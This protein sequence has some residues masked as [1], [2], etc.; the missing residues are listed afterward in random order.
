MKT[1]IIA[2]VGPA[3]STEEMLTQLINAGVNVFRLNFSH[4]DFVFF[5]NIIN[6]IHK[7]NKEHKSHI[8]ILADLQGPKIRVG[9]VQND[10]VML[11]DNTIVTITTQQCVSTAS[12]LFVSYPLLAKEVHKG[13]KILIDDGKILLKVV[14]SDNQTEIK[15]KVLHG[16]ALKSKKGV[17]LPDTK[18]SQPS[19]TEKDKQNLDFILNHR[20]QWI[21]LSFVRSA[22]D[23]LELK[24]YVTLHKRASK[25]RIMAKIE[26][27]EAILD[28][29][30]I[31]ENS[32]GIMV[33]RGDL[34]VELPL[35]QVPLMQK[36]IV[37]KCLLQAK[38][39]VIATQM[40]ESMITNIS[41]TRAETND[42]ANSVLD[43]A[44]ALMLSAETSVGEHPVDVIKAMQRII[45]YTE[46]NS[47][48]IYYKH[49]SPLDLKNN[50]YISDSIICNACNL[51]EQSGAK[52]IIGMTY[53]G[54][55]AF[56]IAAQRPRAA[57]YI[58]TNNH[59]LLSILNLVWGV[60]GFYYDKF[61]NT[62][63]TIHDIKQ[64][65]QKEKRLCNNDLIVNIASTP[66][67]ELGMTNMLK[68]SRV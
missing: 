2:T 55:S 60:R 15:A 41:P 53:S 29:D 13:E 61:I 62:D 43:G 10:E 47:K 67:A 9:M 63:N 49:T 28:I 68:L 17:N 24:Q 8:A 34:G 48:D 46:Q 36:E 5:E 30:S 3:S 38:P 56:A 51:A 44:D 33:A 35:E 50:R 25:V 21:A 66:L 4:G 59:A 42:V 6:T 18:I 22:H 16:G 52:A 45:T 65:L 20:I 64:R 31:I 7:I 54:Y 11:A 1:K 32:D 26:K 27:P 19:L 12:R 14:S 57:I 37:R 40:M 39:V 23:I 58:F